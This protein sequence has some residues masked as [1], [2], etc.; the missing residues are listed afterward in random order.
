LKTQQRI[1]RRDQDALEIAEHLSD[2]GPAA[3]EAHGVKDDLTRRHAG[4]RAALRDVEVVLFKT[5]SATVPGE[6]AEQYLADIQREGVFETA[7]ID[8]TQLLQHDA[9]RLLRARDSGHRPAQLVRRQQSVAHHEI[10]QLGSRRIHGPIDDASPPEH[11]GSVILFA[12]EMEE[13]AAPVDVQ[14]AQ[15]FRDTALRED[16]FHRSPSAV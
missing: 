8:E 3:H 14:L 5:E 10:A 9:E 16:A 2:C 12:M 15:Y 4:R 6:H 7:G 13:T 1:G 11:H